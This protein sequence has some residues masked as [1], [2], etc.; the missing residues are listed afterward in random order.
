MVVLVYIN[1]AI[2][3]KKLSPSFLFARFLYKLWTEPTIILQNSAT[4]KYC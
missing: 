1:S 4:Y 3:I 2:V